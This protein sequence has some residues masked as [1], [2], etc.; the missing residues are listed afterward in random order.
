MPFIQKVETSCRPVL[1]RWIKKIQ[2]VNNSCRP[3]EECHQMWS[4]RSD[5]T[6][7]ARYALTMAII[8]RL[9]SVFSPRQ[10]GVGTPGGCEAAI[11]S[12]RRYLQSLAPDHVMVKLDFE[13]AFNSLHRSDMLLSIRERLPELYAYCMSSYQQPSFLYFGPYVIMSQEGPQ[14]GDPSVRFFFATLFNRY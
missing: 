5:A 11:H 2:K 7:H 14:Q 9:A 4:P 10:L 8:A 3:L 1:L 6:A 12:A 13:N